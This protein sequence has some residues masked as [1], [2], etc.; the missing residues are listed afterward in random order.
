MVLL[1]YPIIALLGCYPEDLPDWEDTVP[2]EAEFVACEEP[3]EVRVDC[4]IDGDTFDVGGCG[5]DA[6]ERIRLLGIDASEVAA[7]GKEAECWSDVATTELAR[8]IE[9]EMVTLTFDAECT[10]LYDRTL[11]YVWLPGEPV[12]VTTT[13]GEVE[14]P[15]DIMVN[16]ELLSDGTVYRYDNDDLR[17]EA[18][19]DAAEASAVAM[20]L[21]VWG[22]CE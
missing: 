2:M 7:S 14:E 5:D 18:R 10:D 16:E 3:R 17:Y 12:S 1:F 11:A 6:S 19:L 15:E 13:E 21:G 22:S 20:G 9:G 4:V 8:F